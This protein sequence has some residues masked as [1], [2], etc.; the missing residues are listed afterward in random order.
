MRFAG[1]LFPRPVGFAAADTVNQ[2]R[3]ACPRSARPPFDFG[4]ILTKQT[5][6]GRRH[7]RD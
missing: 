7:D 6:E 4:S 3:V 1:V 2:H 5:T